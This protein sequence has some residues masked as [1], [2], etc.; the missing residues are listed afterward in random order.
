MKLT[1]GINNPLL[2]PTLS[3]IKYRSV[4]QDSSDDPSKQLRKTFKFDKIIDSQYSQEEVFDQLQIKP[5]IGKVIDGFHATI[6]AYGQTGSGKTYTME[7]YKYED[8]K[9]NERAGKPIISENLD[10]GITIRSIRE[11]FKQA[12]EHKK[13][14]HI[15]IS[16]SFLQIYNEKVFDLLNTGHLKKG[17]AQQSQG[18][19]IRW[20]KNEQFQVENLYVFKCDSADH[21]LELFNKGIKNKIV[22][23]HNLNQSSSRSHCIFSLNFDIV[24]NAQVDNVI[25]S[26]LQLVDL[27][28]SERQSATGTQGLAQ[29]ESIDINKSLF[30]LRKV[31]TG[32]AESSK[33]KQKAAL[34][35][36][37]Y[38]DSKL[39][40]LLK[41]SLGGN[42]YCLMI[43]CLSPSD[44]YIEENISTLNYATKASY[45]S[46]EPVKNEDPKMKMINDLKQKVLTLQ[47][48]LSQANN[49]IEF[50][51]NLTGQP[52]PE[53]VKRQ[54]SQNNSSFMGD[55]ID[56][57]SL[58]QS[59]SKINQS[60]TQSSYDQSQ[61]AKTQ[62]K[63]EVITKIVY[64]DAPQ[65]NHGADAFNRLDQG[66]L[67]QRLIESV[68]MV[69]ELM[70][71][72]KTLR[73]TVDQLSEQNDK[74]ENEI[75]HI[76]IENRDLRDR[77][78]IL[79]SVIGSTTK[80]SDF[81]QLDWRELL[82]EA[83]ETKTST[84]LK[85]IK[86][87]NIAINEMATELIETK[88]Q[89]R[90][91]QEEIE[92]LRQQL[93]ESFQNQNQ[94]MQQ[95]QYQQQMMYQSQQQQLQQQMSKQQQMINT[96]GGSESMAK[97]SQSNGFGRVS[98][99]QTSN[100]Q[101][102]S[103]QEALKMLNEMM[104]KRVAQ[105]QLSYKQNR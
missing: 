64:K 47:R 104:N 43:A 37:P 93:E 95:Q 38:R 77:I 21:A 79:E 33:S 41:Q 63:T 92:S 23:S 10:N 101:P 15:T 81:D 2:K 68:A 39:T 28:G 5:L 69:K 71:S 32:L 55:Q 3:L 34:Q 70:S 82:M 9:Q 62:V 65:Q 103:K 67:S 60:S 16:C 27:A 6:F 94:I 42:S 25:Q 30:T 49:H 99:N 87:S 88:K 31:I 44:N 73:E 22:A 90:Q 72:N 46:N 14:R 91:M 66:Q 105:K 50:L 100:K 52:I 102:Q 57:P 83:E 11:A 7:G 35:H 61:P 17:N 78:E 76:Q 84:N 13:E 74:H 51:S 40:C 8:A 36:I 26:K 86:T 18:L 53:E 89:N 85:P 45:I 48:E 58:N 20:N 96:Y 56:Q 19:R 4:N 59:S 75:F 12:E 1:L 54:Q 97:R 80:Q 98:G 24:D 29:K